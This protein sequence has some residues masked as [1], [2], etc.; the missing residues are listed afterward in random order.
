MLRIRCSHCHGAFQTKSE[1]AGKTA[2]CPQCQAKLR[3]PSPDADDAS[4][5]MLAELVERPPAGS[6]TGSSSN[7]ARGSRSRE[8]KARESQ[9]GD[10]RRRSS[11]SESQSRDAANRQRDKR[12]KPT[13]K[14]PAVD[15]HGDR[16][17]GRSGDAG[18]PVDS[19]EARDVADA[20]PTSG[21]LDA[22]EALEHLTA[23]AAGSDAGVLAPAP[24]MHAGDARINRV[25]I[26]FGV[27]GAGLAIVIGVAV[28]VLRGGGGAADPPPVGSSL[29]GGTSADV[30][31]SAPIDA[32]LLANL[33]EA[34]AVADD[35]PAA[36]G[37]T[38]DASGDDVNA[39]LQR[40][41]LAYFEEMVEL[42]VFYKLEQPGMLPNLWVTPVFFDLPAARQ[43]DA[44]SVVFGYWYPTSSSAAGQLVIRDLQTGRRRGYFS[45]A[46]GL[47][48]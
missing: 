30:V 9:T 37:L 43:R 45:P 35:L 19:S 34:D 23:P 42:K 39:S 41:R 11:A 21:A 16:S 33:P 13:S 4:R 47:E 7:S 18:S 14:R 31:A 38:D 5:V 22:I 10:D 6:G 26:V 32:V 2:R 48:R 15:P 46:F 36:S 8:P 17:V 28:F 44:A 25:A 27:V 24:T 12:A 20:A 40:K 29:T 3:L 1:F